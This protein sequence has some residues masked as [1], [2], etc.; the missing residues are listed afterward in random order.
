MCTQKTTI[1]RH[2]IYRKIWIKTLIP[3]CL[4]V[5]VLSI[6]K[7]QYFSW[8][9]VVHIRKYMPIWTNRMR[10]LTRVLH[11]NNWIITKFINKM[12]NIL[13]FRTCKWIGTF[14]TGVLMFKTYSSK[15][16]GRFLASLRK[17]VLTILKAAVLR[18]T[19]IA[20]TICLSLWCTPE[21]PL[22][23][24]TCHCHFWSTTRPWTY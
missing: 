3:K 12:R 8:L 24:T 15:K 10:I 20:K 19:M 7:N 16:Y 13:N 11:A 14:F 9:C 21:L 1:F 22:H 23:V 4:A 6:D 17:Y 18:F 5:K 2:Y